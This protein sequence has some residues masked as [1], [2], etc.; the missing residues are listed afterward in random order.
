MRRVQVSLPRITASRNVFPALF[1]VLWMLT[2][3]SAGCSTNGN[4]PLVSEKYNFSVEFPERPTEE[5]K[6]NDE[7]LPKSY[8]Q[9]SHDK[10][11]AKDYFTA[12]ATS[13]K[14]ILSADE[15]LVPNESL[16]VLNGVKMLDHRRFKLKAKETGRE[17]EALQTVSRETSSCLRSGQSAV[18][19]ARFVNAKLLAPWQILISRMATKKS[20]QRS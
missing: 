4:Y 14:E 8:W 17:V 15:E 19:R 7:G 3:L 18:E 16:L 12:E 9:F 1:L 13:Y 5:T 11:V 20:R 10:I 6:T 2:L